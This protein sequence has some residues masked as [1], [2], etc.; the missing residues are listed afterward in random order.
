MARSIVAL[1]LYGCFAAAMAVAPLPAV[2]AEFDDASA[3]KFFNDRGCNACHGPDE[4]RIGPPYKVV[5]IR[6]AAEPLADRVES[7]S[8]KIRHGGSGAWGIVP[9]P[10]N[11]R[12]T[13]QEA[14]AIVR[15]ILKLRESKPA[16]TND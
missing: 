6:Y 9:M 8:M 13:P 10:S 15:W 12:V 3:K 4:Q 11:P 7:L 2:S 5:S 14:E 1:S 16:A